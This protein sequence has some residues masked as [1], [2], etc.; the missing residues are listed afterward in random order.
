MSFFHELVL[1]WESE[2]ANAEK[3]P[4][5]N[6]IGRVYVPDT[7]MRISKRN[8]DEYNYS[9]KYDMYE[10]YECRTDYRGDEIIDSCLHYLCTFM[11]SV[12]QTRI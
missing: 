6:A 2:T 5:E 11:S 12:H 9:Y 7:L 8:D 10:K 4:T 3:S 1:F